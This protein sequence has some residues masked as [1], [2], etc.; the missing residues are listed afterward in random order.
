M[1]LTKRERERKKM[2]FPFFVCGFAI[3]TC[4]ALSIFVFIR[5]EDN[6]RCRHIS[7]EWKPLLLISFR[8][9][10]TPRTNNYK[11]MVLASLGTDEQ[12]TATATRKIQ[13]KSFLSDF[14]FLPAHRDESD[15]NLISNF[16]LFDAF[17]FFSLWAAFFMLFFCNLFFVCALVFFCKYWLK[18][19]SF[20]CVIY[21]F[22]ILQLVSAD[23]LS[24]NFLVYRLD[25]ILTD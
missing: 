19:S 15:L 1:N 21:F 23:L 12:T 22:L 14:F 25:S 11:S 17:L 13:A 10:L 7:V 24:H 20:C 6:I 16:C 3:I 5:T 8:T 9:I 2:V 4:E 18:W